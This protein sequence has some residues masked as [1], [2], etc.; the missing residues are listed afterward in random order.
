MPASVRS[1]PLLI[2]CLWTSHGKGNDDG[3]TDALPWESL[4]R[5]TYTSHRRSRTKPP[6]LARFSAQAAFVGN[7]TV[8]AN[9][10]FSSKAF[11]VD[12]DSDEFDTLSESDYESETLDAEATI[13]SDFSFL[14]DKL[15][16][17][18]T[19]QLLLVPAVK[20]FWERTMEDGTSRDLG[21]L[22]RILASTKNSKVSNALA[23]PIRSVQEFIQRSAGMNGTA[24][25]N[26][27]LLGIVSGTH[28]LNFDCLFVVPVLMNTVGK[29]WTLS[30]GGGDAAVVLSCAHIG[31][32]A[33]ART[34]AVNAGKIV[35]FQCL[36][37]WLRYRELNWIEQVCR[38]V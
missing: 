18:L 30:H 1:F 28:L 35:I 7:G 4:L 22:S 36:A 2:V 8:I 27:D 23:E 6:F 24:G 12:S 21:F 25:N 13:R 29:T 11:V 34:I 26:F 38:L 3:L 33:L 31:L 19:E 32:D 37:T 20:E 10:N 16:T 17:A 9:G 5:S 14:G 15:K